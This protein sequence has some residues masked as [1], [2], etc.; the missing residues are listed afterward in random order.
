MS[1][2]IMYAD[3]VGSTNMSMT[4][5]VENLVV[6]IRAFTHEISNVVEK[7]NGYILKYV[8][9]AVISFFPYNINNK[10]LVCEKSVECSK[11]IIRKLMQYYLNMIIL[12]YLSK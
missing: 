2:V 9:D 6:L 12:N 4:L 5:S 11:S 8:G 1:L 7:Y 3:L 10:Y